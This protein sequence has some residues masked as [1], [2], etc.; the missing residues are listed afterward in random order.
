[1]RNL[2]RL[3][4]VYH[5]ILLSWARHVLGRESRPPSNMEPKLVSAADLAVNMQTSTFSRIPMSGSVGLGS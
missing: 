5:G 3:A 1:M 4:A 2:T